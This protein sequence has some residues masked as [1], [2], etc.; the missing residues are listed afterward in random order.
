MVNINDNSRFSFNNFIGPLL[1]DNPPYSGL[2]IYEL[3][4]LSPYLAQIGIV[5]WNHSPQQLGIAIICNMAPA[6]IQVILGKC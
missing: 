1:D 4:I 5:N 3:K 2:G 6:L